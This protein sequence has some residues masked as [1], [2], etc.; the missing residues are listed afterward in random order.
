MNPTTRIVAPHR[1]THGLTS[2][3][4]AMSRDHWRRRSRWDG[5]RA[6]GSPSTETGRDRGGLPR[7]RST[8]PVGVGAEQYCAMQPRRHMLAQARQQFQRVEGEDVLAGQRMVAPVQV[9][10]LGPVIRRPFHRDQRIHQAAAASPPPCPMTRRGWHWALIRIPRGQEPR[11][12]LVLDPPGA[13][14][15]HPD[16]QYGP[17]PARRGHRLSTD[18]SSLQ[19]TAGPGGDRPA[20]HGPHL[21]SSPPAA[22]PLPHGFP[23]TITVRSQFAAFAT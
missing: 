11:R 12:R 18:A 22:H 10:R 20:P 7:P 1:Q 3:T 21:R 15:Q 2:N 16:Q 19:P 14:P 4:L 6:S 5:D 9:G 17:R 13:L 8:C 23:Q